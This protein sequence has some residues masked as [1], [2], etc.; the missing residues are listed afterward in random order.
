MTLTESAIYRIGKV[1]IASFLWTQNSGKTWPLRHFF[2]FS[3][4]I[5]PLKMTSQENE[6]SKRPDSFFMKFLKMKLFL[7][8]LLRKVLQPLT[9]FQNVWKEHFGNKSFSLPLAPE[10][11]TIPRIWQKKS[12]FQAKEYLWAHLIASNI[13]FLLTTNLCHLKQPLPFTLSNSHALSYP[14]LLTAQK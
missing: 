12:F 5:H 7:M 8:Q 10:K 3:K 14:K 11:T 1:I 13:V 2:Q 6:K 9:Y 4:S